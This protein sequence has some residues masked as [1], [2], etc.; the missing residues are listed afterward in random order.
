MAWTL[1][2]TGM[3][4][5]RRLRTLALILGGSAL[6]GTATILTA[7]EVELRPLRAKVRAGG[8]IAETVAGPI[9]YAIAG[10]GTPLLS[11]HGASGGYDQGLLI[12]AA[13]VGD[14]FLTIAPSRFGYLR[15]PLPGDPSPAAQADAH[16]A[17][18]ALLGTEPVIVLGVSAGAPS[19]MHLALRHPERVAALVLLSPL[20]YA[21]GPQAPL[22]GGEAMLKM[23]R[24]GADFA[25]WSVLHLRP[26]SVIPFLGVPRELMKNAGVEDQQWI[27]QLLHSCLPLSMRLEGITND[28]A[29]RLAIPTAPWPLEGIRVPTLILTSTDDLFHT[30]PAAEYAAAHIP[31]ARLVVYPTGGHL[32]IGH[33]SDVRETV[34]AFL[35]RVNHGSAAAPR[36]PDPQPR[37]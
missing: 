32:F 36:S 26:S 16:A 4:A 25:Y 5:V 9:E 14:T 33:L 37:T 2:S 3:A 12:A 28:A 24:N 1:S 13:L 21:P 34:A 18:L 27:H 31:G 29:V 35:S 11:I 19:A 30:Q 15:T 8:R 6:V 10:K 7:Y 17:L 22:P 23:S 20:G